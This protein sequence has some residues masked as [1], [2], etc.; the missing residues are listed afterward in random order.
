[1]APTFL[2]TGHGKGNHL[3]C[4]WQHWKRSFPKDA[5]PQGCSKGPEHPRSPVPEHKRQH[6]GGAKSVQSAKSQSLKATVSF[7]IL[8]GMMK[9]CSCLTEWDASG[10]AVSQPFQAFSHLPH[11]ESHD[12]MIIPQSSH[13]V[14]LNTMQM[15]FPILCLCPSWLR[16]TF[17]FVSSQMSECY[18]G[19]F[20]E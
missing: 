8:A 5:E 2:T 18:H 11:Q 3:C 20:L 17:A 15:L 9:S 19:I 1:M 13:L 7:C 10:V 16:H 12:L 4:P 14:D 6:K